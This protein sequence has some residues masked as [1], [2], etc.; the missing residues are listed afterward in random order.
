MNA[1]KKFEEIVVGYYNKIVEIA[2]SAEN[3]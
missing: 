1:E 2:V 3:S